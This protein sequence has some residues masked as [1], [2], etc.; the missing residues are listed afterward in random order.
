VGKTNAEIADELSLS[1][2]TVG[3]HVERV[4]ARLG[5]PNRAAATAAALAAVHERSD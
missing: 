5:V 4:L 3:R 2:R 1:P